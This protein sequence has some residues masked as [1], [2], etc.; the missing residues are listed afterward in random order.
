MHVGGEG[1]VVRLDQHARHR[2]EMH[3]RVGRARRMAA[4]ITVEAEMTGQRIERLAGLRQVGVKRVDAGQIERLEIDVEDRVPL[5]QQMGDRVAPGL[6]GPAGEDDAFGG[7]WVLLKHSLGAGEPNAWRG[8]GKGASE[9]AAG[10]RGLHIRVKRWIG[11]QA[12]GW[13]AR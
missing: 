3:D 13:A 4:F 6:A 12:R 9:F 7:H 5:G 8:G 10:R 2:G 1:R 11:A